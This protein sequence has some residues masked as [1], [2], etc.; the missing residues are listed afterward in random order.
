MGLSGNLLVVRKK[1]LLLQPTP[2]HRGNVLMKRFLR[3]KKEM[4]IAIIHNGHKNKYAKANAVTY[5]RRVSTGLKFPLHGQQI[6]G[7]LLSPGR[8][9][10]V[11]VLTL[12]YENTIK[13]KY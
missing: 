4:G 6:T 2:H 10:A 9:F 1:L 13:N 8:G 3:E 12:K 5:Y 7:W 11:C